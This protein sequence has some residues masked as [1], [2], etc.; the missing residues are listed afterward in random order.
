MLRHLVAHPA[1]AAAADLRQVVCIG[2]QLDGDL[3][4]DL[5]AVHPAPLHNLY[6]PT[7]ATIAVSA[8]TVP[9]GDRPVGAVPIGVPMPGAHLHVLDERGDPT[10]VG[11]PGHLHIGG[12]PLGAATCAG[13][14]TR[15]P[16]SFPTRSG[17]PGR[18][19]TAPATAAGGAQPVP[20]SSSNASTGR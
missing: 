8:Y 11:V 6:G 18:G 20:W 16:R 5:A 2:E 10:P 19:F 13:P 12:T 1:L 9:P 17:H 7:E 4:A 15:R 3:A 14:R